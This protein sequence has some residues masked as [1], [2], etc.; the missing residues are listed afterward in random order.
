MIS[1]ATL[2]FIVILADMTR[3]VGSTFTGLTTSGDLNLKIEKRV[4]PVYN[5]P[6]LSGHP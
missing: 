1:S 2:P 5:G 6:I 4:E 3:Q